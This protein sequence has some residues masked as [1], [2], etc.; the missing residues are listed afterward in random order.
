MHPLHYRPF[1]DCPTVTVHVG[2]RFKALNDSGAAI[3]LAYTSVYSITEDCYKAKIMPAAVHLKTA[4]ESSMSSLGKATLHLCIADF[5][6]SHNFIIWDKL[7]EADI[8]F[9]IN[10]QKRYSLLYCWD[11]DKLLFIQR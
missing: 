6:F 9:G 3:S 4:D 5:K 8:V 10:L 2:K 11:S 7:P 1:S